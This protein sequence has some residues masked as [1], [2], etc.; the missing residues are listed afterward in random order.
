VDNL[1]SGFNRALWFQLDRPGISNPNWLANCYVYPTNTTKDL[2]IPFVANEEVE[3]MAEA[4]PTI[5]KFY[6]NGAL[7]ASI[8]SPSAIPSGLMHFETGISTVDSG[9]AKTI[10]IDNVWFSAER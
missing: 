7:R 10:E 5:V 4:D 1:S 6:V 2:G 9:V 8:T 3:L